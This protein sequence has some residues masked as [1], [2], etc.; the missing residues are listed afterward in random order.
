MKSGVIVVSLRH[1]RRS[2]NRTT[3]GRKQTFA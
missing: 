2:D 3:D 1:D